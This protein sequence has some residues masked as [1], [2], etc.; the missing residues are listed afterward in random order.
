MASN[1]ITATIPFD[2]D[3]VHHGFLKLPYS[4]NDS[5]WGAIMTP[6]CVIRNGGGPTAL[7]TGANH[8]DEYE[9]PVALQKLAYEL[10]LDKV[11]GRVIIV[12]FFNFPAFKAGCRNSPIDDGNMNRVFPGRPD[13]S[14]TEKIAD[15]F[16]TALVP[17][18]DVLV[19][20]HSGGKTLDFLPLA[21]AHV[22][23][24]KKQ[25][26]ACVAAMLAFNAPISM[27]LNGAGDPGMYDN[28][29]E[30]QGK[31]FVTTELGGGGTTTARSVSITRKG[32]RNLL[33]HAGIVSGELA[34]DPQPTRSMD[35]PDEECYLFSEHDGLIEPVVDLGSEIGRGDVVARLWPAD[36]T[37]AAPVEC[38]VKRSGTLIARHFPGLVQTGDC[39]AVVAVDVDAE[40]WD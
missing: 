6:I 34:E 2:I 23:E 13:G 15:Y 36:R 33:V 22:L 16:T 1:P 35:M 30:A 39:I 10:D 20:L 19:D 14:V 40:Q 27:L 5:A 9:G 29:A 31:I 25:Q 28:V 11:A 24:D 26:A 38:R 7:L 18:A 21:A 17:M 8:G 32:I 4:R 3:G 12:P 37:G